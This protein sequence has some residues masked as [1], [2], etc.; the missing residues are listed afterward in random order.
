MDQEFVILHLAVDFNCQGNINYHYIIKLSG[1]CRGVMLFLAVFFSDI[2]FLALVLADG[3][4]LVLVGA[5]LVLGGAVLA[6][7]RSLM[8]VGDSLIIM[9]MMFT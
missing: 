2:L 3:T 1:D 5:S 4:I 7:D 8:A 6:G 9:I